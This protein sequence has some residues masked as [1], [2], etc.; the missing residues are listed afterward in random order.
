VPFNPLTSIA[1]DPS[2]VKALFQELEEEPEGL[3]S[4]AYVGGSLPSESSDA[5]QVI[6]TLAV[7]SP[8]RK[9][10]S[11][12][13]S[14]GV[15]Y[16][17]DSAQLSIRFGDPEPAPITQSFFARLSRSEEPFPDERSRATTPDTCG[18]AIDVPLNISGPP[19][20]V[21][22]IETPGAKTSTHLPTLEK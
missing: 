10:K 22:R 11:C 12:C 3:K 13:K 14:F 6:L 21:E 8:D 4:M 17:T 1:R 2:L 15:E 7:D 18:A 20:V 19:G 9:R 5:A 16:D